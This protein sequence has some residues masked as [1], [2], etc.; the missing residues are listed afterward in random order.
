MEMKF[1]NSFS[2]LLYPKHL[3][4]CLET[5]RSQQY[6]LESGLGQRGLGGLWRNGQEPKL[7]LLFL[8]LVIHSNLIYS[9]FLFYF[10]S[11]SLFLSPSFFFVI[12]NFYSFCD[13]SFLRVSLLSHFHFLQFLLFLSF[14]FHKCFNTGPRFVNE[15]NAEGWLVHEL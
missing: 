5:D 1:N 8:V 7:Y 6:V 13:N 14:E 2:P 4:K 10:F 12:L 11:Y 3:R 15:L 9:Q